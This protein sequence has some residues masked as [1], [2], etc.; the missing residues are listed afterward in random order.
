MKN[1]KGFT[2]VELMSVIVVLAII[3]AI[4]VP[5]YNKIRLSIDKKNYENKIKLIEVAAAKYAED[6]HYETIFVDDLIKNGFIEADEDGFIKNLDGEII[7]C[8]VIRIRNENGIYYADFLEDDIYGEKDTCDRN[9]AN[10]HNKI[11][12]ID[13]YEDNNEKLTD[14]K[15]YKWW[16]NKNVVLKVNING[17][18][19]SIKWY[20]GN[21][22]NEEA[23]DEGK[24]EKKVITETQ[25]REKY[26]VDVTLKDG[27]NYGLV[28][29]EA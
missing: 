14:G 29:P 23:D 13:I 8:N 17:D 21:L 12:T 26:I 25:M 1:R 10:A 28:E 20:R 27:K 4:A 7:N 3:I 5:T 22:T 9:A 6:T 2:L 24:T 16:T 11:V 15:Y 19:N 18:Y